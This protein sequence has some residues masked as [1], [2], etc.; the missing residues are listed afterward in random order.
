MAC[1]VQKN[2][3][4]LQV[5]VYNVV[6][7]KMF[8]SKD[9]LGNIEPCPIFAETTFLLQMP[10][11]FT[12]ALVVGDKVQLG[13]SLEREFQSNKEWTFQRA[14]EDLAFANGV[15]DFLL[16]NDFLLGEN[17]HGVDSTS[18]LLANLEDSAK[19]PSTNEFKEFKVGRFERNAFLGII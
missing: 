5:S 4:R 2:V 8:Q 11:E 19:S 13:I 15:R 14:L 16:R 18:I 7:V 6:L 10:E 9:Q 1:R 12:T 17:L 3:L